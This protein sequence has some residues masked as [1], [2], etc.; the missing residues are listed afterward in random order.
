MKNVDCLICGSRSFDV[1]FHVKDT[2][3]VRCRACSFV[4]A[5]PRQDDQEIIDIYTMDYFES[6]EP[7]HL[8]YAD[9]IAQRANFNKTFEISLRLISRFKNHG[10]I[11]D[12]GCGPGFFV[13]V[14]QK[15]NWEAYGIDLSKE[16]CSYAKDKL[17]IS[18]I[19]FGNFACDFN[20]RKFSYFFDVVTMW[21]YLEHSLTPEQDFRKAFHLLKD[22]G[23]LVI[24]THDIES[25]CSKLLKEKWW[26]VAKYKEH[27]YHF[28]VKSITAILER[29]G[30]RP[31]F[32]TPRYC[33]KFVSS[34]F[35]V[36]RSYLLG[37]NF[38]QLAS[39]ILKPFR[40]LS[41]YVNP[42]DEMIIIATKA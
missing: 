28:S 19:F 30:F 32:I 36:E 26:H 39:V 41:I 22:D 4:Y 42:W 10:R 7:K 37:A 2:Q 5:N 21:E 18:N 25:W 24:E 6:G 35:L 34:N 38:Q 27:I 1:V 33:G 20:H 8:G 15:N 9:Y 29:N 12:V 3:I 11:L 13:E 17:G 16:I 14:A 40:T 23:I 31:T